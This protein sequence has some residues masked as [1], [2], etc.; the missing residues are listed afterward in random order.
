MREIKCMVC[1]KT[2]KAPSDVQT[3]CGGCLDR[4]RDDIIARFAQE[5]KWCHSTVRDLL[6]QQQNLLSMMSDLLQRVDQLERD[7]DGVRG[8]TGL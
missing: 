5:V 4:N 3:I 2:E 6:G 8:P 7:R 1:G